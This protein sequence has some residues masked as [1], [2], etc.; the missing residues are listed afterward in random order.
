MH[1]IINVF[2]LTRTCIDSS[3]PPSLCRYEDFSAAFFNPQ[4]APTMLAA[5][6]AMLAS[7]AS[8]LARF[9]FLHL[10]RAMVAA[11]Y[12]DPSGIFYGGNRLEA[13]HALVWDFMERFQVVDSGVGAVLGP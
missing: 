4:A 9:G 7:A 8:H 2:L 13:S 3:C 11:Q 10:K 6:P 5:Y 12:H 1:R